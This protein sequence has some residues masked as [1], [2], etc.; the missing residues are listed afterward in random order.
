MGKVFSEHLLFLGNPGTGK[1]TVA[2]IFSKIYAALGIL[3]KGH[4]VETDRQGLVAGYVGQTAEK[5]TSLIDKSQGGMLFLD[6]AY[7]LINTNENDFGKE[8]IDILLKRMED[9]RG[10][11]IVIAAGY[12]DEMQRFISSNP[13]IQSRFSKS[14][15]FEDYSPAEL[16]EIVKRALKHDKKTISKEAEER[17]EKYFEELFKNRDKKFGNARIVRNILDSVKQKMLLRL[18]EIPNEERSEDKSS[19]VELSDITEVLTREIEAKQF[20]VKG[21]PLKLQEYI[22]ELNNMIGIDSVKQ[23]LFK[24][25][26]FSKLSQ[27]KK[28]KGLHSITRNFN[29]I[30]I[31]NAGTGKSTISKLLAKIFFELGIL[32][33]GHVVEI[34]RSDIFGTYQ[35]QTS[36]NLDK[37]IQQAL[38]GILHIKNANSVFLEQNPASYEALNLIVK[39]LRDYKDKVIIVLS[40]EKDE[41]QKV[42]NDLPPIANNFPNVFHFEDYSPR[43]LLAIAVNLSERNGY[44]LDEGALQELLDLFIKYQSQGKKEYQNGLLARNH[45]YAAITN[46]E[47]RIFSIYEQTD[48]D[49]TTINLEDVQKIKL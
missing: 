9:D 19:R 47:E 21:D 25:I 38:G 37:V 16:M 24:L 12:T 2:R 1:T 49:L 7:S 34:E 36:T 11:F 6:E 3:T 48:V 15:F 45:L 23:D 20:E 43:E 46:Q 14:F 4:L 44:I 10:K 8:A 28:E 18:S 32:S 5:T 35:G 30:F 22:N 29:S 42:L 41:M 26:S 33:K 27:L 31:G 13:G 39:R 40:G 17:L